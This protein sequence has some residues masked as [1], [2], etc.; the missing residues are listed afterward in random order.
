MANLEETKRAVEEVK[1]TEPKGEP[2]VSITETPEFKTAL[3]KAVG[4]GVSTIQSLLSISKAAEAT[5][6]EETKAIKDIQEDYESRVTELEEKQFSDDPEALKGY[7]NT[8]AIALRDKKSKL[9]DIEQD[10]RKVALDAREWAITMANKST[11]LL[12]KYQVPKET[13]ELCTSEEQMDTIAQAFPEVGK[14]EPEKEALKF[15]GAG[16]QGKG[17]DLNALSSTDLIA[18]GVSEM[19]KK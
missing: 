10:Q 2:T 14:K 6:R 3:D 15:A 19:N 11:E 18:R 7:R 8:K 16:E 12:K 1:P 9:R 4:K 17:V 13:L 5:A